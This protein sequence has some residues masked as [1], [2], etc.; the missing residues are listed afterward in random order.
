MKLSCLTGRLLALALASCAAL[1]PLTCFS[2]TSERDRTMAETTYS[3]L[4]DFDFLVGHWKVHHR[5][6]KQRLAGSHEW[7]EFE[8][9]SVLQK[10]MGGFGTFDDNVIESP[11]GT[12]RAMTMRVFDPKDRQWSI[13]WVD[14]RLPQAPIDPPLRGSFKDGIG[15]FYNDDTFNGRPIRVRFIWSHI[16]PTSARW[17][18]AFSEDQG[19]TWEINWVMEFTRN[20]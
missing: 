18:Q 11:D 15:T 12:Y 14:Q 9:T 7:L 6:L 13:W 1:T 19:A 10:T 20:A 5:R 17:E 4:H 3:E 16:T 2:Q 8:G